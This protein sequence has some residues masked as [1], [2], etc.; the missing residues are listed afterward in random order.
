VFQQ[1]LARMVAGL[2]IGHMLR[3]FHRRLV[4]V[5]GVVGDLQQHQVPT[6]WLVSLACVK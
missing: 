2:H 3:R 6:L 1:H 4:V 5:V